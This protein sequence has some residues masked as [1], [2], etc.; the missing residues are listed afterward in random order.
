MTPPIQ[1]EPEHRGFVVE[2]LLL[3]VTRV[4]TKLEDKQLTNATGFFFERDGRLFVIT[5][6]HVVLDE[7]TEH[8]PDWIEVELHV[9]EANVAVTAQFSAPLYRDG[10]PLWRQG[11]DSAGTVD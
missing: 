1:R 6:R 3:A 5:N 11:V 8:R 9:D 4:T 2:S 7:P 10:K